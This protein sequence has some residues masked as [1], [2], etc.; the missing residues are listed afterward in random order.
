MRTGVYI[1]AP[2][3]GWIAAQAIK[4]TLSLRRDGLQVD[5]FVRSGGMPSSHTSLMTALLTVFGF[6]DG[7]DSAIFALCLAVT[8]IVAYDA[9][10]VRQTTGQQTKAIKEIAHKSD[11]KLKT[12]IGNAQ[13]HTIP[14]IAGGAAVGLAVGCLLSLGL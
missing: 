4:F 11:I 14:Q 5:D 6:A 1:I 7:V 9:A 12:K 3:A 10:G 13:G 2:I 8:G